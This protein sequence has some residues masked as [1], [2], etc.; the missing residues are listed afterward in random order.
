MGEGLVR[1]VWSGEIPTAAVQDCK[2]RKNQASRFTDLVIKGD[3]QTT[4]RCC[5]LCHLSELV[6]RWQVG[7]E[8]QSE[9]LE[10]AS[11]VQDFFVNK[12]CVVQR[13]LWSWL[14]HVGTDLQDGM[15]PRTHMAQKGKDDLLKCPAED[16]STC[17]IFRTWPQAVG[18]KDQ[19]DQQPWADVG[20]Q[21][22][23]VGTMVTLR[24]FPPDGGYGG[25]GCG[26]NDGYHKV[27]GG[28]SGGSEEGLAVGSMLS[29][30]LA[31]RNGGLRLEA[32][33]ARVSAVLC[34]AGLGCC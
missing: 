23:S 27:H 32:W 6:D 3:R 25:A 8:K 26:S 24:E 21:L 34:M 2:G 33:V 12:R 19:R 29:G 28:A 11:V 7:I 9:T 15:I 30:A 4:L 20:G 10:N 1:D 18:G 31:I 22:T 5:L 17:P 13:S 16:V 14:P